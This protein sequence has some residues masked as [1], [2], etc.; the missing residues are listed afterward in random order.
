[1]ATATTTEESSSAF[2]IT[3][4]VSSL[5]AG[6]LG[7]WQEGDIYLR[8]SAVGAVVLVALCLL[9]CLAWLYYGSVVS[10]VFDGR[11]MY[12]VPWSLS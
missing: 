3:F 9:I 4:N 11:S 2:N 7:A 12:T 10:S 1:M 5:V 8:L 6:V